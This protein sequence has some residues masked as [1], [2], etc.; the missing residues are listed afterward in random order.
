MSRSSSLNISSGISV[1][2][3]SIVLVGVPVERGQKRKIPTEGRLPWKVV[4]D[5]ASEVVLFAV[6]YDSSVPNAVYLLANH[7]SGELPG[8]AV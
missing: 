2:P 1:T 8:H 3:S 7:L 5:T 6:Y 4:A